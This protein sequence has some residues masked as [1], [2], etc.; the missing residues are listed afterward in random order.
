LIA[1]ELITNALKYAF[2]D[3]RKGT[4]RVICEELPSGERLLS[5]GDDGV[6]MPVSVDVE[7]S[8]SLGLKLIRMFTKK[9]RGEGTW[10]RD[11]GGLNYSLRF[12]DLTP[13]TSEAGVEY[14]GERPPPALTDGPEL[15]H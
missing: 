2:A 3:G 5:I 11:Q 7:N 6:G 14:R 4:V 1:N 12:R 15:L 8:S 9:L 13:R 10:C